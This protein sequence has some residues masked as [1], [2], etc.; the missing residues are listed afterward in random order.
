VSDLSESL[1]I[2]LTEIDERGGRGRMV[3][4]REKLRTCEYCS[5][6]LT[7]LSEARFS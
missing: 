6:G 4:A 1:M 5:T 2:V 3:I 7:G